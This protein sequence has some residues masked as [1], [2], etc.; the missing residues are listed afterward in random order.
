MMP[1]Q[2]LIHKVL[3]ILQEAD[4]EIAQ[5][6]SPSCFD[7]LAKKKDSIL[8]LKILT[9]IDSLYEE[10]AHDLKKIADVLKASPMI[11]GL[12]SKTQPM[13]ERTLYD[14]YGVPAI[15]VETFE[16]TLLEQKMPFVYSHR[17]GFYAHV[18][19][20]F[21]KEVR[22]KLNLSLNDL[23][24]EA[25]ISRKAV[26]NYEQ[27]EGAELENVLRLQGAVGDLMLEPLNPFEFRHEEA[28]HEKPATKLE[29][30]VTSRLAEMGFQ[31]AT[32]T[33]TSFKIIGRSKHDILLTGLEKQQRKARDLHGMAHTLQQHGM[34]VTEHA[35]RKSLEGVPIVESEELND[36]ITTKELLKLLRELSEE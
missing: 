2:E 9:N 8:L 16:E 12:V 10:Q 26:Y 29:G 13:H 28:K 34:L 20:E 30:H 3:N 15:S 19:P 25:G 22:E 36:I 23:A 33:K 14:R 11:I 24:R 6:L 21:L 31:T 7:I 1:R 4:Y 35:K 17:G 5:Q 27:G 32:V 18:D